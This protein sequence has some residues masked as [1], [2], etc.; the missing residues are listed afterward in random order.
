MNEPKTPRKKKPATAELAYI[1]EQLRPLTVPLA[2]LVLDP[3]NARKHDGGNLAAIAASLR[4]FG[5]VKPLVANKATRVIEAGNGTFLAAQTLGWSHVAVV[6]VEHDP[7]AAR[8]FAIA[9]NRTAELA[10]WDDTILQELLGEIAHDSPDL[11][12]ELL[13]EDLRTDPPPAE[14]EAPADDKSATKYQVV[15]VLET[16]SD[17]KAFARRMAREKRKYKT[18]TV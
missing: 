2:D 13:L 14:E 8:G 10:S 3:K 15:V 6:W 18:L 17:Q 4:E 1:A 7:A 5:Q 12:A 11:Y 9:D 16:E